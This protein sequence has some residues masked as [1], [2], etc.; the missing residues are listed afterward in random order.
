M[1][2]YSVICGIFRILLTI[3]TQHQVL[4][5]LLILAYFFFY[6]YIESHLIFY[7]IKFI[8]KNY[9]NLKLCSIVICQLKHHI[10]HQYQF[11]RDIFVD[12]TM[13]FF[14]HLD[15]NRK[16]VLSLL[17]SLLAVA[18]FIGLAIK[19]K[20]TKKVIQEKNKGETFCLTNIYQN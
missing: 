3:S 17:V 14:I 2:W 20:D 16:W 18:F 4:S 11:I 19:H 12:C 6:I 1:I 8:I 5:Y 13:C 15:Y 7:K 10:R 9:Y